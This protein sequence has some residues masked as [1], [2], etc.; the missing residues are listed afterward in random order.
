VNSRN[1]RRGAG[2]LA[3]GVPM[4]AAACQLLVGLEDRSKPLGLDADDASSDA[5]HEADGAGLDVARVDAVAF[6]LGEAGPE[7][8]GAVLSTDPMNCG[9]C[10]RVCDP[11]Y[12]CSVGRCGVELLFADA[13][14]LTEST[15]LL[16]VDNQRLYFSLD[17]RV[18]VG[19]SEGGAP[20]D[21]VDLPDGSPSVVHGF[22]DG[23]SL[24]WQSGGLIGRTAIDD[25]GF[26]TLGETVPP[27]FSSFAHDVDYLY[28]G[29]AQGISRIDRGGGGVT[30]LWP[31][32]QPEIAALAVDE[33]GVYALDGVP[34]GSQLIV[35]P[36]GGNGRIIVLSDLV[37]GDDW[38][39]ASFT[40]ADHFLYLIDHT[41]RHVKRF[42]TNATNGD[43]EETI[44]TLDPS[45]RRTGTLAVDPP[46][47]YWLAQDD[48]ARDALYRAPACGGATELVA[49]GIRSYGPVGL[50]FDARYVY[51]GSSVA[52]QIGR[53]VK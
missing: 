4:L 37:R 48:Q 3:L 20:V 26:A 44:A 2:V 30:P 16:A 15:V 19:S 10:G 11:A 5:A 42:P 14:G 25:G 52:S 45:T 29:N 43:L 28:F 51:W 1:V 47:V 23:T 18:M 49:D 21:I 8:C 53:T 34:S 12:T 46:Y 36:T 31:L 33:D 39:A 13:G 40:L 50:A 41:T 32:Q 6:C 24:F 7:D 35:I 38:P 9:H 17:T 22:V 27:T